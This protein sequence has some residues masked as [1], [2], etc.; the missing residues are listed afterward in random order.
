MRR[1]R[2][3]HDA[4]PGRGV[5]LAK[6]IGLLLGGVQLWPTLDALARARGRPPMPRFAQVGSIHPLNL[7][8]LVAPYLFA[9]RVFG[10]STHEIE[11]YV[12]AVPLMLIVWLVIQRRN[13]G[14]LRPLARATAWFA[15]FA[16]LLAMGQYGYLYGCR[17]TCRWSIASAARAVTS[18]CSSCAWRCWRRSAS[19]FCSAT[20][21]AEPRR[22]D[23]TNPTRS[24]PAS[25]SIPTSTVSKFEGLWAVVDRQRRG[26]PG[27]AA[28]HSARFIAPVLSV[29]AGP[30]LF[31]AAAL[32]VMAAAR[33]VPGTLAALVLFAA[34]DLGCYGMS[35]AV[36]A[37]DQPAGERRRGSRHAAGRP[38]RT[39]LCPAAT[40]GRLLQGLDRQPDDP[41]RLASRRRLRRPGAAAEARL[42]VS[43][44]PASGG[45]PPGCNA[46]RPRRGSPACCPAATT[47]WKCPARCRGCRLVTHAVASSDPARDIGR[48]DVR[49]DGPDGDAAGAAGRSDAGDVRVV[50]QRPGRLELAVDC[51]DAAIAA[52]FPRAITPA[53]RRRSTARRSRCCASTATSSAAWSSPAKKP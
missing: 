12:G 24:T 23:R 11:L 6:G 28:A 29:L 30:L 25:A 21:R 32:L 2:R 26:G 47:G 42:F 1:L 7:I 52:W 27:R 22:Q 36:Y 3:L 35:Y 19:F 14:P 48:I 37:A 16:L 13:L 15:A 44:R 20:Y 17:R 53:G 46:T 10:G 39:R 8:Q 50:A 4:A 49:I 43:A 51:A 9:D 31:A 38:G 45:R 34:A 40:A 18:C 41:G 5:V 33:G